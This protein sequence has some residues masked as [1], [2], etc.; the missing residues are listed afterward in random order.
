MELRLHIHHTLVKSSL[1]ANRSRDIQGVF[2]CCRQIHAELEKNYISKAR[3]VLNAIHYFQSGNEEIRQFH[4]SFADDFNFH[5]QLHVSCV[6][7][8]C[9][10]L[11]IGQDALF[12]ELEPWRTGVEAL[13]RA[14]RLCHTTFTIKLVASSHQFDP[15]HIGQLHGLLHCLSAF[16]DGKPVLGKIDRLM[17]KCAGRPVGNLQ[18]CIKF[19]QLAMYIPRFSKKSAHFPAWVDA[20]AA[21]EDSDDAWEG[22]LCFGFDF[23][24]GL[25]TYPDAIHCEGSR[26]RYYGFRFPS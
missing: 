18:N 14:M 24:E 25:D 8:P 9:T 19:V 22:S 4:L 7:L 6:T 20:W 11:P 3:P 26:E 17:L 2:L 12:H 21:I 10:S 1:I 13:R 16:G 5:A 15:R 23:V